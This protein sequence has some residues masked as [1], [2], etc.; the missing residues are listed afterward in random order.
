MRNGRP[1][2]MYRRAKA[3]FAK[4]EHGLLRDHEGEF[5]AVEPDS[6]DYLVGKDEVRVVLKAIKRHPGKKFG[7]FRVGFVPK[8]RK[9][10]SEC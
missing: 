4:V 2:G 9:A 3:V 1:T 7:F 10:S 6:G 5:V 8:L